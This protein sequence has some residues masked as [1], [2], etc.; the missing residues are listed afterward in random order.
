MASWWDVVGELDV[1]AWIAVV[2]VAF[3]VIQG[4]VRIY[5]I[6]L[7]HRER[8]TMIQ[9]GIDPGPLIENLEDLLEEDA[10]DEQAEAKKRE[11]REKIV[12]SVLGH[13]ERMAVIKKGTRGGA[14]GEAHQK[15]QTT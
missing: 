15:E 12:E 4:V 14:P 13:R 11:M 5:K 3:L 9:K 10:E 6:T 8:M 1:I 7:L 2:I